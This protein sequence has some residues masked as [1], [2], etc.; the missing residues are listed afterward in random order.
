MKMLAQRYKIGH[1]VTK[2]LKQAVH[3][4]KMAVAHGDVGSMVSFGILYMTGKGVEQDVEKGKELWM[5]AAAQGSVTAMLNLKLID[6][7]QRTTTPSFTPTPSFC[8]FC[9]K[10]HDP[11]TCVLNACTGCRCAYYCCKEHQIMDWKMKENGHKKKCQAIQK[12]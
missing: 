11:P 8:S 1:G 10:A 2:S 7:N 3:F 12:F 5:K 9:G 6:Q 4:Y